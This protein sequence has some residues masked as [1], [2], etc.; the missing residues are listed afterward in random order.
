MNNKEVKKF[1]QEALKNSS[2]DAINSIVQRIG[3]LIFTI[4]LARILLPEG[5]GLFTLILSIIGVGTI[6]AKKGIDETLIRY[7]SETKNKK[8]A[9]AYFKYA[10]KLKLIILS[11]SIVAL[12]LV[13]YPLAIFVFKK[14]IF[15]PLLLAII[16]AFIIALEDFFTSLFI[17]FKN[18]K[19][20][21][22]KEIV[23]QISRNLL[24]VLLSLFIFYKP[25]PTSVFT[26]LILAA[27]I[28]FSYIFFLI[29]QKKRYLLK[30]DS[31]LDEKDK[32][33]VFRFFGYYSLTALTFVLLGNVDTLMIGSFIRDA[34]ALGLYSAAFGISASVSGLITFSQVILPLLVEKRKHDLEKAFNL[35]FRYTMILALPCTFGIIALSDKIL[36]LIYGESY[37]YA[38]FALYTLSPL[39][40]LGAM[41]GLLVRL[42]LTKEKPDY[43]LKLL[44]A[45]IIINIVLNFTFIQLFKDSQIYGAIAGVGL[46][47]TLSWL[48]YNIG[49][50][51]S[52]R[53]M[54]KIKTNLKV[55]IKPLLASIIMFLSLILIQ[56]YYPYNS[57]IFTILLIMFGALIYGIL[58]LI[59]RALDKEDI[60]IMKDVFNRSSSQS[61]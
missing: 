21:A 54:L 32:R 61:P 11:I 36:G 52:A 25:S 22:S 37:I 17:A 56:R 46:A 18:V 31:N 59:F 38:S 42:F 33:R 12:I 8:K 23:F 26:G 13:A 51:I 48:I 40:I 44:I 50:I 55:I 47:T 60:G 6:F 9:S 41:S 5:F 1:K 15:F 24:V 45:V 19:Y 58:I 7:I 49:L 10:L 39:I 16:Y 4:I 29:Y 27:L 43:Y 53:K 28:T 30:L 20:V 34:R 2:W 14:P 35:V 3:G 57:I